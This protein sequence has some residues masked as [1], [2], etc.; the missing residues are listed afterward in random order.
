MGSDMRDMIPSAFIASH[1]H[2][3]RGISAAFPTEE[4]QEKDLQNAPA[5]HKLYVIMDYKHF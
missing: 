1:G 3:Y 4:T 5:S 2:Q